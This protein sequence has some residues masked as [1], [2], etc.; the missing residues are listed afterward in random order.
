MVD[1]GLFGARA[2]CAGLLHI[3]KKK[4]LRAVMCI[5]PI[6]K[7]DV[8]DM[9]EEKGKRTAGYLPLRIGRTVFLGGKDYCMGKMLEQ[10]N[11]VR[12]FLG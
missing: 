10:T 2:A 3:Q 12:I 5:F 9:G 7:H 1:L 11:N 8:T 4:L 6:W